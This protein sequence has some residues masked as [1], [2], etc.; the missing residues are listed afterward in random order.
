MH[1]ALFC[2]KWC[3]IKNF[4]SS[5]FNLVPLLST[6][7]TLNEVTSHIWS[8]FWCSTYQKPIS[9]MLEIGFL[10]LNCNFQNV[11]SRKNFCVCNKLKTAKNRAISTLCRVT[12]SWKMWKKSKNKAPTE[13]WRFLNK[14]R[15]VCYPS[16]LVPWLV[17]NPS[18][19]NLSLLIWI[20]ISFGFLI[21]SY[22][23]LDNIF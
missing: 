21:Y 15:A 1:T 16:T 2:L 23:Y 7:V 22:Q 14:S 6:F 18:L 10:K 12:R 5:G 13:T 19:P 9:L 11:S 3:Q 20:L 17:S 4:L 8:D